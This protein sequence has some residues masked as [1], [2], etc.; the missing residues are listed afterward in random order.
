MPL[1]YTLNK[2]II[3]F[4]CVCLC[5]NTFLTSSTWRSQIW[6]NVRRYRA[7]F[8]RLQN[9]YMGTHRQYEVI[10]HFDEQMNLSFLF[11]LRYATEKFSYSVLRCDAVSECESKLIFFFFC[12]R[13]WALSF[14]FI[15]S[16]VAVFYFLKMS[17]TI[18][19]CGWHFHLM[20][21]VIF[22]SNHF[23]SCASLSF[24]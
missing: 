17:S 9:E 4:V 13:L 8:C 16:T 15:P 11:L 23:C 5:A 2:Y 12:V 7:K 1:S 3:V 22:V 21:I 14:P 18:N 24:D 19:V 20:R 6:C 10:F